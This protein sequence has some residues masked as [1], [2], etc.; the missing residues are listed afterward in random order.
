MPYVEMDTLMLEQTNEIVSWYKDEHNYRF[1]PGRS[2]AY[3]LYIFISLVNWEKNT[4]CSFPDIIRKIV[5][6]PYIRGRMGEQ[7]FVFVNLV[8]GSVYN[9][10]VS[11]CIL[12]KC[13]VFA[14]I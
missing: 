7:F 12:L 1:A 4:Y 6:D 3:A 8:F 5:N 14:H 10:H 13:N 9:T 11:T 2:I